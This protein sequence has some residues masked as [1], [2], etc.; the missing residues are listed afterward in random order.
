MLAALE[1]QTEQ[2]KSG[3]LKLDSQS[4]GLNGF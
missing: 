2:M 1:G 4:A 3:M